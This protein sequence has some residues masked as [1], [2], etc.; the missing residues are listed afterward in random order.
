MAVM[1][2]AVMVATVPTVVVAAPP[3]MA[4]PMPVSMP[5]AT[6][7]LNNC[8]IGWAERIGCCCGHSGR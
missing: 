7:D 8:L 3:V 6:F 2:P 5:M 4:P 1:P